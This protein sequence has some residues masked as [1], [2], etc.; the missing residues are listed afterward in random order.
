LPRTTCPELIHLPKREGGRGLQSLEHEI[1]ILRIQTQMRLL[2]AHGNAGAV[3][4]A[5]KLRHDRETETGTI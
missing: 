1:D 3:V 2:N 5:A 4:R